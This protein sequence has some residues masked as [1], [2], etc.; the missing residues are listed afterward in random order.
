MR[1][2]RS[3]GWCDSWPSPCTLIIASADSRVTWLLLLQ[4]WLVGSAAFAQALQIHQGHI[5]SVVS[6]GAPAANVGVS[7]TQ[8]HGM[9]RHLSLASKSAVQWSL[10]SSPL[11]SCNILNQLPQCSNNHL[12]SHRTCRGIR[13][14]GT[15]ARKGPEPSPP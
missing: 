10:P 12:K 3:R 8:T 9:S 1:A 15:D 2:S 13:A 7:V 5:A 4:C 11:R 14:K 6:V